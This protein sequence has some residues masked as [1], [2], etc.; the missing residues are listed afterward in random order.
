MLQTSSLAFLRIFFLIFSF[1]VSTKCQVLNKVVGHVTRHC[2]NCML[3]YILSIIEHKGR[4]FAFC[5]CVEMAIYIFRNFKAKN[6]Y[7][8]EKRLRKF[9]NAETWRNSLASFSTNLKCREGGEG[10]GIDF[11]LNNM[12]DQSYTSPTILQKFEQVS[13]II[14]RAEGAES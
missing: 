13:Q 14:T 10:G 2:W 6:D 11:K 8:R 5:Q 12:N 9:R 1:L 4:E 3:T 7:P